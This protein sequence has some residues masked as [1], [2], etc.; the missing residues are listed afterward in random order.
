MSAPSRLAL[1]GLLLIGTFVPL[2]GA[3]AIAPMKT[4]VI[5]F[6]QSPREFSEADLAQRQR[7]V[8]A[9]AARENAAGRQLEP[10]ILEPEVAR[11]LPGASG[12]SESEWPITALLFLRATDLEDAARVAAAHPAVHFGASV[13]VRA[14]QPPKLPRP[15]T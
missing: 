12:V 10:R 15:A 1:L 6:R 14:W 11:P 9:W 2:S 5:I 4:F 8:S 7:E 13:E 3:D